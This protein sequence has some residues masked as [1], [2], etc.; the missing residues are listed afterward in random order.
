M[1]AERWNNYLQKEGAKKTKL[2]MKKIVFFAFVLCSVAAID[3][4]PVEPRGVDSL[5][6]RLLLDNL[7]G[8]GRGDLRTAN[9]TDWI[10]V[11]RGIAAS[12]DYEWGLTKRA[13]SLLVLA[14][15]GKER[16]SHENPPAN[17]PSP[18]VMRPSRR[19]FLFFL[20][21]FKI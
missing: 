1:I 15:Q 11:W 16:F 8:L 14:A 10:G 21:L 20:F 9:N 18:R 12:P 17:A 5:V 13:V 19:K 2:K 7:D 4:V 6:A 3:P